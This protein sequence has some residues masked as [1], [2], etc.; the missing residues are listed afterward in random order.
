MT[1]INQTHVFNFEQTVA[2]SDGFT[3]LSNAIAE[4]HVIDIMKVLLA[5]RQRVVVLF[6][7]NTGTEEE[8]NK[9]LTNAMVTGD[10]ILVNVGEGTS[11]E[12]LDWYNNL[13][14]EQ[15]EAITTIFETDDDAVALWRNIDLTCIQI[16]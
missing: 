10:F 6:R 7:N 9:W 4:S 2:S 16:K 5:L 12:K 11:N 8:I 14:T 13:D 15:R 1:D 3:T